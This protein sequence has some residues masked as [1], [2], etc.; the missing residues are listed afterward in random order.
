M[1]ISNCAAVED[2]VIESLNHKSCAIFC[3]LIFNPVSRFA[4][5]ASQVNVMRADCTPRMRFNCGIQV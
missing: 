4:L 5:P 3:T 1:K 2:I